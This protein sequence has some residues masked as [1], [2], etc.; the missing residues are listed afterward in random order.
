MQAEEPFDP[1]AGQTIDDVL[2]LPAPGNEDREIEAEMD[3]AL[4]GSELGIVSQVS[5]PS[6]LVLHSCLQAADLLGALLLVGQ[7]VSCS[8]CRRCSA[9]GCVC[10]GAASICTGASPAAS[11]STPAPTSHAPL[12]SLTPS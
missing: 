12:H 9:R 2:A 7:P 1:F 3:S 4:T 10:T 5:R 8:S 6:M 11:A